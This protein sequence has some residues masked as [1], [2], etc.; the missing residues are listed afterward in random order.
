MSDADYVLAVY[1]ALHACLLAFID[2]EDAKANIHADRAKLRRERNM[3]LHEAK[4]II[5]QRLDNL[6]IAH[7]KSA[8]GDYGIRLLEDLAF[9][10]EYSNEKNGLEQRRQRIEA[11]NRKLADLLRLVRSPVELAAASGQSGG[12]PE[13]GQTTPARQ[14]GAAGDSPAT[15]GSISRRGHARG[16]ATK[17]LIAGLLEHH[18]YVS[19]VGAR[20]FEPVDSSRLA[21]RLG[22]GKGTASE[23]LKKKFGSYARY[24]HACLDRIHLTA[25]LTILAGDC[26]E[27]RSFG[28]T[29]PGEGF[30]DD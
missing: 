21:K 24:E 29:P 22:V 20:N 6:A 7:L 17:L 8:P 3:R 19:G 30:E 4:H 10:F 1:N 14:P 15:Q 26:A 27:K 13:T 28:R 9:P 5:T 18:K 2:C 16:D 25:K 11:R 23:F 12:A